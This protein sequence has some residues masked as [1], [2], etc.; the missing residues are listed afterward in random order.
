MGIGA[1]PLFC[2][3]RRKHLILLSRYAYRVAGLSAFRSY[4]PRTHPRIQC[5][6]DQ[7]HIGREYRLEKRGGIYPLLTVCDPEMLIEIW[8]EMDFAPPPVVVI[9]PPLASH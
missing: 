8:L 7:F 2:E 5:P 6:S 1:R 9:L 4:K 3:D